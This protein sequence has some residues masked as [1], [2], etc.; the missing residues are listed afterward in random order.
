MG[1]QEKSPIPDMYVPQMGDE[2]VYIAHGHRQYLN[3]LIQVSDS[4]HDHINVVV[5][6]DVWWWVVSLVGYILMT[7]DKDFGDK[8]V[9]HAVLLTN[10]LQCTLL[11]S[12]WCACFGFL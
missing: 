4:P 12:I 3:S 2:V 7:T 11:H 9:S 10:A 8:A 1:I 5:V 6:G